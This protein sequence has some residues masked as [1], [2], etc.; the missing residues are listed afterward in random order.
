MVLVSRF[1]FIL[2]LINIILIV[3]SKFKTLEN[4]I[5]QKI[6]IFIFIIIN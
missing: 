6:I 5:I 4:N 3:I 2:S 1:L